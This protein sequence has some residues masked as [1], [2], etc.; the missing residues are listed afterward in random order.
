LY[1]LCRRLVDAALRHAAALDLPLETLRLL[2][3][4]MRLERQQR[5]SDINARLDRLH[6]RY[7]HAGAQLHTEAQMRAA[8][9]AMARHLPLRAAQ[10][11]DGRQAAE[12]ILQ[13]AVMQIPEAALTFDAKIM[14]SYIQS[15]HALI[16]GDEAG[17]RRCLKQVVDIWE[18]SPARR[19]YQ[20]DA[21]FEAFAAYAD[22]ALTTLDAPQ[23]ALVV[24]KYQRMID[25]SSRIQKQGKDR[26]L[27]M[28]LNLLIAVNDWDAAA[29][30]IPQ[31][32]ILLQKAGSNIAAIRRFG[33]LG[34]VTTVQ[35][36]LEQWAEVLTW[37]GWLESEGAHDA[38]TQWQDWVRI[39]R[40]AAWYA[41]GDHD[42]IERSL[43]QH[44]FK[45]P[46]DP[47]APH[48]RALLQATSSQQE[49]QTFAALH[50]TLQSKPAKDKPFHWQIAE[51]WAI[52]QLRG[53]SIWAAEAY[54][55]I[56]S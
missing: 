34:N 38:G 36:Y 43:D 48:F 45:Y 33:F 6:A 21:H 42:Q 29:D 28:K 47:L 23:Q 32:K 37:A 22:R 5:A 14:R 31:I 12:L 18:A 40:W 3:W 24:A 13:N 7:A 2:E 54:R 53:I 15:F 4:A 9:D 51:V 55:G 44:Q 1:A 17:N 8:Y 10:G 16:C 25:R 50:A 20:E 35:F 19:L 26:V 52:A 11:V 27:E 49:S 46:D 41:L 39:W 30:L 56:V